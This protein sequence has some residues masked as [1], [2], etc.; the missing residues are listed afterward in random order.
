MSEDTVKLQGSMNLVSYEFGNLDTGLT[1]KEW[2]EL[3]YE[4]QVEILVDWVA[5]D[6]EGNIV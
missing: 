4:S 5:F 3:D 2:N 6:S 1:V